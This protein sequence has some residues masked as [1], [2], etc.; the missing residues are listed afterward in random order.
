M[1]ACTSAWMGLPDVGAMDLTPLERAERAT[2]PLLTD[3]MNMPFDESD[4]GKVPMAREIV[5]AVL[6]AIREPSERLALA[7]YAGVNEAASA[8][9]M[10]LIGAECWRA[11]IEALLEEGKG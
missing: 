11:G 10:E 5:R 7:V 6:T 2:L 1:E 3:E 9:D 4:V 8:Q